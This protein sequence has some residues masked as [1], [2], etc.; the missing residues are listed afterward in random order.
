VSRRSLLFLLF[1]AIAGLGAAAAQAAPAPVYA[2]RASW[3]DT[4]L[5]AEGLNGET[6]EG[7][8]TLRVQNLGDAAGSSDLSITDELPAGVTITAIEWPL[9]GA[10]SEPDIAPSHCTGVGTAKL[11]CTIP[12]GELPSLLPAPGFTAATYGWSIEPNGYMWPI[13]VEVAVSPGAPPSGVN[14]AVVSGGSGVGASDVDQIPLNGEPSAF[15]LVPGGFAADF[16]DAAYP[17]G[18]PSRQAG[19]HPFEQRVDFDFNERTGVSDAPGGDGHRYTRPAGLVKD[20]EVTLPRGLIGNPEALP[21]CDPLALGLPG[22]TGAGNST[23]CPPDTQVGYMNVTFAASEDHHGLG[24]VVANSAPL[25]RIALYNV[26]PPRGTPAD[27]AFAAGGFAIGHIYPSLDPAHDYAI[28]ALSPNISSILSV[29][30]VEVTLW[31]VPGDPAHDRYRYYSQKQENGDAIGAP[32]G[33]AAIRPLFTNPMD[34]GFENGGMKIRVDS[35]QEPGQFSPVEEYGSA[36]NVTGCEDPRFRFHPKVALQPSDR[37]AGAPTGLDV[38]LEVPQRNDEVESAEELYAQNGFLKGISTPPIKKAVVTLPEGMT[39]SPSAAQGLGSCTSAEIAL[40]T[41]E[42]VKCPDNSQYGTLTLHTPILPE[43]AP[44]KGFI[45]IAKQ[46]D[47]PF[48]NFLS[49]YLAIEEPERGILIKI[50]GRVDLDP[51]T[52][53]ITTTFDELPQFPVS[54]MQMTFKGGVRAGLVEPSTC[55]KKTIKAEFFTWQDPGTAHVVDSSYAITQKPNGSPCVNNLGERPFGPEFAAGTEGNAGGSYSPFSLRLVRTDEDQEFSQLGVTLPPGLAAKFAGVSICPEAGI[56]QAL[57]RE[58]TEGAGAIEQADPSCPASSQIGTTE[59]G[60]GVG[61]PL[62]WVPGKVYLAGPYKGAP[63]SL[64]VISPAMVGPFDLGVIA[65]RT[66]LNVN[67]IT[68]QGEALSD[69]FPQIFQGIPVRIRDIRLHL[70]RPDFTLNPT[71]CA[72]KQ[73]QAHFTGTGGD[74]STTADDTSADLADRFQAADCASLGFK[75][76]LAFRLFG[77]THRGTHPKLKAVVT[78]PKKGAYA[79]IASASVTLPHSEFLD[80]AHIGTVCTRVQFAAKACPADSIYGHAVAKTPLFDSPL[81]GPVYLRSSGHQLPDLVAA[82]RGPASQ[83]VEVDLDGRIDS[84]N[85]GIR[86]TFEVVPD[87]PV[88]EFVLSMQG[89]KKGLLVNST[90]LCAKTN[91]A[92]AKFTAQNGRVLSVR[93]LLKTSCKG[94]GKRPSGRGGGRRQRAQRARPPRLQ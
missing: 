58:T 71:S 83:P 25:S 75:P 48:H 56:A 82:L 28:K 61:V 39:L 2:I 50:P 64:V 1:L 59:V 60:A 90:D 9:L 31:G 74:V 12:A 46:G 62:T 57:S 52:G 53:Q 27:F 3:G 19:D 81:A 10:G 21:K 37:H 6:G 42:P 32:F 69:P 11:T 85:G 8:L 47:N 49:I 5:G 15:G 76:K 91:R 88:S 22:A 26:V 51:K 86:N 54:D 66:A 36:D 13:Y 72:E 94:K 16:F 18:A 44:P 77:G 45:Y 35:Y 34:C 41:N 43:D 73:I 67:P 79:N 55:G 20:A 92:T 38:H 89:G 33:S 68:A 4:N 70:D 78:Y 7:E 80:Q 17:F 40:G 23:A 30:G 93:P 29:K 14:T 24:A 84:V 87:A 65:V 63:L